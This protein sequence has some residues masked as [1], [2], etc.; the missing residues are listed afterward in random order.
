MKSNINVNTGYSY[1]NIPGIVNNSD[2]VSK[3]QTYNAG[4]VL[5]SN[6]SENVDFNLS[7]TANFNSVKNS[8][9]PSL[10]NNYFT[11]TAGIQV[12]LLSKNGWVFQNDLNNQSYHGLT[13]GFNQNFWLWN[14]SVGKKFL[15]NNNGELRVSVFDLL[16]QNQSIRRN[17]EEI[18]VEDVRTQVLRQY[19]M[20]TFSYKLRNFVAKK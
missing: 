8:I 20:L 7:Y 9:Q 19:F 16:R 6:I 17:V 11:S 3:A 1:S 4:A 18:Y 10:N 14:I 13:D 5:A 12:N 15:K 2:N